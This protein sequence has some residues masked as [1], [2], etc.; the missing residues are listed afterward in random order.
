MAPF[1]RH[2]ILQIGERGRL[3][4]GNSRGRRLL[5]FLAA[6]LA[7]AAG[8]LLG[9][10]LALAFVPEPLRLEAETLAEI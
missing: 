8:R 7:L 3:M 1:W 2:F 5:I 4:M 10:Q 9:R 6:A